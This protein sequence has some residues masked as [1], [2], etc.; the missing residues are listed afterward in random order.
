MITERHAYITGDTQTADLLDRISQL[1]QAVGD[2]L[3]RSLALQDALRALLDNSNP[4]TRIL[5]R[6][7]LGCS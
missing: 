1:Q 2:S 5:A 4:Y 6:S 7:V 3:A